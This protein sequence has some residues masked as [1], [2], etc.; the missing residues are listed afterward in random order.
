MLL[1]CIDSWSLPPLTLWITALGTLKTFDVVDHI[2][3]YLDGV[4]GYDWH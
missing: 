4:Q 1:D 2:L 3:V